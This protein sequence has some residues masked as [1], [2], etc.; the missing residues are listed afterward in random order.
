M[1]R[2]QAGF[3]VYKWCIF[4]T[5]CLHF[6]C[7]WSKLLT[8]LFCTKFYWVYIF[9]Y[10]I[11]YNIKEYE[12]REPAMSYIN[13]NKL[14]LQLRF[15]LKLWNIIFMKSWRLYNKT[16]LLRKLHDF[17]CVF[18]LHYWSSYIRKKYSLFNLMYFRLLTTC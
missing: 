18:I 13:E 15:G 9:I 11:Y 12:N 2:E 3:L 17:W 14:K 7:L 10:V 16:F 4:S 1:G 8:V 6:C 5:W